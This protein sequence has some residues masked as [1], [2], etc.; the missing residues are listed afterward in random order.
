MAFTSEGFIEIDLSEFNDWVYNNYF[1]CKGVEFQLGVPRV[2]KSNQTIEIDFAM[3][4]DG[5]PCDWGVVPVAV[6][7]WKELK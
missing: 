4:T 2:N 7:Q 1:P 3:S 5:H 6:T